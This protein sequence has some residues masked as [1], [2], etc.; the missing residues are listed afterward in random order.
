MTTLTLKYFSRLTAVKIP[1]TPGHATVIPVL[2]SALVYQSGDWGQ[3][4]TQDGG[5]FW[6]RFV[7]R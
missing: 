6:M 3:K 1:G 2:H 7:Q 4:K 5:N